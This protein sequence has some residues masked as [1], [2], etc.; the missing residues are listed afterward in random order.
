MKKII[1]II[2]SI[3]MLSC[4][5]TAFAKEPVTI[6]LNGQILESDTAAYIENNRTMVPA[7]AIFEA[8][9]ANVQ[10]DGET[11]TVLMLR[12]KGDV[13]T[14]ITLQIGLDKAFVNNQ[15]IALDVPAMIMNNR[16][17]VPLR[18]I[19][20]SFD[21]KI[22]WDGDTRSVYIETSDSD[23]S[24]KLEVVGKIGDNDV[25]KGM[26]DIYVSLAKFENEIT[27][28]TQALEL[29]KENL[30]KDEAII[31]LAEDY[32]ITIDDEFEKLFNDFVEEMNIQYAAQ[33]GGDDAFLKVLEINGL[34]MEEYKRM[35]EVQYLQ[36]ML[37]EKYVEEYAPTEE[38]KLE[39]YNQN[40]EEFK[41]DGLV[42]KHILFST[43]AE[44]GK[45]I[46][47]EEMKKVEK[48][49]NE[50]YDKISKGEDFDKLMQE[51]S[52]DPGLETNPDGYTFTK[53]EM[54][55][56]FETAAYALKE[57]EVSKPVKSPYGYH[58][59]KL[60][61]KIDYLDCEDSDVSEYIILQIVS[62]KLKEDIDVKSKSLTV[63][64]N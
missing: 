60:V 39:Y 3:C 62:K 55:E 58:I 40:K 49:A 34:T 10:W 50:I 53:G 24:A 41:Y 64:W 14:S 22:T 31:L 18:F 61:E 37:S 59:I 54:V 57:G 63:S 9:G 5:G 56:E 26:L 51:Y 8:I 52:E 44:D 36:I 38:Q 42:A 28:D 1:S 32:N 29:A 6:Y 23:D 13:T 11:R 17:Y 45:D 25:T 43:L 35:Q 12:Q 4:L 16:T 19:I 21:E 7:R 2:L 15:E 27:D 30:P 48:T 47:P 33:I 46:S 20:E